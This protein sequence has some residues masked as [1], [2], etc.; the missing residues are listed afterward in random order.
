[1]AEPLTKSDIENLT[2]AVASLYELTSQ[3][4]LGKFN[5]QNTDDQDKAI[6][7]LQTKV[8]YMYGNGKPGALDHVI[9]EQKNQRRLIHMAHGALLMLGWILTGLI[10]AIPFIWSH[11]KP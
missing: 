3:R 2:K 5:N 9:S 7:E 8:A 1:M 6:A 10:P 11:W 4:A